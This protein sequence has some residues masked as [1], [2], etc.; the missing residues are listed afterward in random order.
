MDGTPLMR[1][2]G[3][4][5]M[6][7]DGTPIMGTAGDPCCCGPCG[8]CSQ[9]YTITTGDNTATVARSGNCTWAGN[10][11]GGDGG[12]ASISG[13]AG[14]WT[15]TAFG[16]TVTNSGNLSCPPA[17]GWSDGVTTVAAGPCG[18]CGNCSQ[19]Y[20]VNDGYDNINLTAG[21]NCTW[22]NTDRPMTLSVAGGNWQI[23][24]DGVVVA[25]AAMAGSTCPPISGWTSTNGLTYT[26]T[27]GCPCSTAGNCSTCQSAIHVQWYQTAHPAI[28]GNATVVLGAYPLGNVCLWFYQ[29]DD[30]DSN[31]S[32]YLDCGGQAW[33]MRIA[34]LPWEIEG[35]LGPN[36]TGCPPLGT[37]HFVRGDG[38]NTPYTVI[39]S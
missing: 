8:N 34:S 38:F 17:S 16:S 12:N 29:G 31:P 11:T 4:P 5:L 25:T 7:S 23:I 37:Y 15:L 28:G 32:V 39:L 33:G 18:P 3:T 20:L 30:P 2:D 35:S 9:C 26:V 13:G 24:D 22:E 6:K 14:N 10:A 19:C 1:A 21:G 36:N 27:P